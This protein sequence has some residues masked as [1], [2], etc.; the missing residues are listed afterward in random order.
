MSLLTCTHDNAICRHQI[1]P[2]KPD[3]DR[4]AILKYCQLYLSFGLRELCRLMNRF[5]HSE[6]AKAYRHATGSSWLLRLDQM[7]KDIFSPLFYVFP[8]LMGDI[9]KDYSTDS[10]L[11]GYNNLIKDVVVPCVLF[12]LVKA[13]RTLNTWTVFYWIYIWTFKLTLG[14]FHT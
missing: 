9:L 3:R 14:C 6:M 1:A 7:I 8:T 11:Q 10:A 2:I 12:F 13:S 5:W 4:G